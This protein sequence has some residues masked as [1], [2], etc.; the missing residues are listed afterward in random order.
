LRRVENPSYDE[1]CTGRTGHAEAAQIEFDSEIISFE[2]ILGVSGT[3][4]TQPPLTDRAMML[5][6]STGRLFF[7][8]TKNKKR[9]QR[10]PKR[11]KI[12]AFAKI[13]SHQKLFPL[14][15]SML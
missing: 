14:R 2:K 3:P 13:Q 6:C 9:P 1:V 11:L 10:N 8:M 4:T 5:V 15:N 12:R 7:I